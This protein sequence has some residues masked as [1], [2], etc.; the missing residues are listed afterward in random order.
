[1]SFSEV[2]SFGLFLL[3]GDEEAFKVTG[4]KSLMVASLDHFI[5]ECGAVFDGFGEY[6]QE[7]P[8]VIVVDQNL[9][10][11]EDGDVLCNFYRH[12]G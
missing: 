8:F 11:L 12:I 10:F 9:I 5:E 2:A 3:N 4:P 6:L 1:M 7:V